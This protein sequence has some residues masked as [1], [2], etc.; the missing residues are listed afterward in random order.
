MSQCLR[1][2]FT[3]KNKIE[4]L[5]NY[6]QKQA[7]TCGL[8]GMVQAVDALCVRIVACGSHDNVEKFLESLH[9]GA[10]EK[11]LEAIEILFLQLMKNHRRERSKYLFR[12]PI[13]SKPGC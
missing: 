7:E 1:I 5:Y 2:T 11:K 8:E 4:D 12:I 6:V 3:P 9:K 13:C 10:A